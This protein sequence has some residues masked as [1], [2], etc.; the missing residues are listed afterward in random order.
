M[1]QANVSDCSLLVATYNWP[2]ALG[3]CLQ[4]IRKQSVLP[5][6]VIIADDGSKDETRQLIDEIKKT[7]PVKILHIWQPDEGFQLAKIRNKAFAVASNSY[8]IQI[9]GD[10]I[11]HP[12]FVKDHLSLAKKQHFITGSRA[13]LKE[14]T[15]KAFL[16]HSN[17]AH[18][19]LLILRA[20][21]LIELL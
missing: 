14:E 19:N 21:Y 8:I 1:K 17:T 11:L 5:N 9:D 12:H 16:L 4:S 18:L 3:L 13:I 10:L 6:E 7:F 2:Q 20:Y 15:T